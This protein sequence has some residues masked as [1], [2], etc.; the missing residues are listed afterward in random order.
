MFIIVLPSDLEANHAS[1]DDGVHLASYAK[2]SQLYL[3]GENKFV[4][5]KLPLDV[6]FWSLFFFLL[7]QN[8]LLTHPGRADV[9]SGLVRFQMGYINTFSFL[10]F[11]AG[12]N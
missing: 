2:V 4:K 8:C 1:A 9:F 10:W 12:L 3:V 7:L 5:R 11:H 6:I